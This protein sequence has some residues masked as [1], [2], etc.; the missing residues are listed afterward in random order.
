MLLLYS[1]FFERLISPIINT[2]TR[3][4]L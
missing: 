4:L 1:S 3:M 2:V